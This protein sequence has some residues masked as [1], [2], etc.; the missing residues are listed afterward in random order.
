M[1]TL[2]IER[3]FESHRDKFLNF[4][5]K[6]VCKI[7]DWTDVALKKLGDNSGAINASQSGSR[8]HELIHNQAD[9]YKRLTSRFQQ[10]NSNYTFPVAT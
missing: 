4:I 6:F 10:Q 2:I 1:Y 3:G 7:T 9:L 5:Y 8:Q